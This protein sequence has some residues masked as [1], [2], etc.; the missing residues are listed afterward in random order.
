MAG[1]NSVATRVDLGAVARG[2]HHDLGEVLARRRG[3][4]APWAAPRGATVIRSSS[5]SGTVRWFSPTT[6][7]DT[8]G[9]APWLRRRARRGSDRACPNR[10][11]SANQALRVERPAAR[12]SS[13]ASDRMS[14]RVAYSGP[15]SSPKRRRSQVA[16]AGLRPPVPIV[17]TRSPWRTTDRQGERAVGGVVGRV[18]PHPAGLAGVEHRPVDAGSPVA[19]MASQAPS[20]SPGAN[21]A[22]VEREPARRR[23]RPRTSAP[24]SGAT[25]WTSAPASSRPSILR[26]AMRPAPTTTQRRPATRGSPG[27]REIGGPGHDR[28]R[29]RRAAARRCVAR[30]GAPGRRRVAVGRRTGSAARWR[31]RPCAARRRRARSRPSGRS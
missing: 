22:L 4:A 21:G 2:E 18:H 11:P 6:T 16:R 13:R 20:R 27:S 23:P 28:R 25:T 12:S 9:G 24:T 8:P 7:R 29:R 10:G 5:S 3:R 17:T 19:V 30:R 26:A 14:S 1:W 31:G 15:S